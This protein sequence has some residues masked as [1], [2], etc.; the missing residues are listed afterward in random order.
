MGTPTEREL[1]EAALAESQVERV[2]A[3]LGITGDI[4]AC[5][6]P[7]LHPAIATLLDRAEAAERERNKARAALLASKVW[8]QHVADSWRAEVDDLKAENERLRTWIGGETFMSDFRCAADM[9]REIERLRAE[10]LSGSWRRIDHPSRIEST[11]ETPF[12]EEEAQPR[13]RCS[14]CGQ[15]GCEMEAQS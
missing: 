14:V 4:D 11:N 6:A 12:R 2:A 7:S 5:I 8:T 3:A 15:P 1:A 9:R 10:K 13:K